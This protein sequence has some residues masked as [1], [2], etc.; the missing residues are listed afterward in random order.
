MWIGQ[1]LWIFY[2]LLIFEPVMFFLTQTLEQKADCLVDCAVAPASMQA[3]NSDDNKTAINVERTK[4]ILE[5]QFLARDSN[6]SS[7]DSL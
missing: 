3:M 2:S 5:W 6:Q 7:M 4:K 1:K